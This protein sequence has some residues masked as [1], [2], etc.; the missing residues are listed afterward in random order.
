MAEDKC[1]HFRYEDGWEY[2]ITGCPTKYEAAL[3]MEGWNKM[4][5]EIG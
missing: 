4:R 5:G 2:L 3:E 1:L